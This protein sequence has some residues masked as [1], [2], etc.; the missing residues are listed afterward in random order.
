[1][2]RLHFLSS[3]NQPKTIVTLLIVS[4]LTILGYGAQRVLV[5]IYL[6]ELGTSVMALGVLLSLFGLMRAVMNIVGGVLNDR[7]SKK[8]NLL[9]AIVLYSII[10]TI[11]LAW[12]ESAAMIGVWR[13][14]MAIGLSWG[15]TSILTLLAFLTP[16]EI[17]GTLYGVQKVFFWVGI[18]AAGF[19]APSLLLWIDYQSTMM[20]LSAIGCVGFFLV[21]TYVKEPEASSGGRTVGNQRVATS[22]DNLDTKPQKSKEMLSLYTVGFIS[23]FVEDGVITTFLPLFLLTWM[24]GS[25]NNA[26]IQIGASIALYTILYAFFQPLG[27]WLSDKWGKWRLLVIG[28]GLIFMG[29]LMW[30]VSLDSWGLYVM[31]VLTGMGSGVIAATAEARASMIISDQRKGLGL[32]LWRFFRDMGSFVGP[33]VVG[34][35]LSVTNPTLFLYFVLFLV[36]I[37]FAD[38]LKN[39]FF[40]S[41]EKQIINNSL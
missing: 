11:G 16:S 14:V 10:S 13:M 18:S 5:P 27:G 2:D 33:L 17:R 21:C 1:M 8:Y 25:E 7:F 9:W 26:G 15:T 31:V 12:S 28:N 37:S 41:Y 4:F 30:I 6:E 24:H 38:S 3:L 39:V 20:I 36:A 40:C 22:K 19:I 29:L 35:M 32:G 23:K 34:F